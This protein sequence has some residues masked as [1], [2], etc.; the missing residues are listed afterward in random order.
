LELGR[1]SGSVRPEVVL[2]KLR[3]AKGIAVLTGISSIALGV[4]GYLMGTQS[5]CINAYWI[6]FGIMWIL[7]GIFW[8]WPENPN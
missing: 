7:I 5:V 8:K 3:N 2:Q 6:L 4:L 1:G